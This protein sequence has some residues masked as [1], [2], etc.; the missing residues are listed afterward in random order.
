MNNVLKKT[1]RDTKRHTESYGMMPCQWMT[2]GRYTPDQ[3]SG[4]QLFISTPSAMTCIIDTRDCPHIYLLAY[5][6]KAEKRTRNSLFSV[7]YSLFPSLSFPPSPSSFY[8]TT[9]DY[10]PQTL[11]HTARSLSLPLPASHATLFVVRWNPPSR[12]IFSHHRQ[13]YSYPHL[14]QYRPTPDPLAS[15]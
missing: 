6:W 1:Q 11:T 8:I 13:Y 14:P 7:F 9:A 5:L 2:Q 10:C 3:K 15:P 4:L 12:P